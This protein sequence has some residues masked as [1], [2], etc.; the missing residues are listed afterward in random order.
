M[1]DADCHGYY[2]AL[3]HINKIIFDP[4]IK[5][6][7]NG[8]TWLKN[9]MFV[10]GWVDGS[11]VVLRYTPRFISSWSACSKI[12]RL[13]REYDGSEKFLCVVSNHLCTCA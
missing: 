5:S 12:S 7:S 6:L 11:A 9:V 1:A 13:L 10:D 3:S 4:L 2:P 8:L